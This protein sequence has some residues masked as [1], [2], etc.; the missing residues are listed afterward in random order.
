MALR[1]MPAPAEG[2]EENAERRTAF[3][4][5]VRDALAHLHDLPYLQTHPLARAVRQDVAR[6]GETV[7]R[8]LQRTLRDAL[9]RLRPAAEGRS[10][11][12]WRTFEALR[13]RYVEGLA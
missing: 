10:P 4:R 8:V 12:A 2:G 1:V 6:R 7:G 5:E 9:E 11:R 3:G 13:L